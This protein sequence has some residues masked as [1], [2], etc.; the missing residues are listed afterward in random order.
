[1]HISAVEAAGLQGLREGQKVEFEI[2][3]GRDG[4]T[5]AEDIKALD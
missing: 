3:P 4:R 1:M 2:A 5:S